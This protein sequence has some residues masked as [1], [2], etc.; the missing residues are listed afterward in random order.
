[1][2]VKW[3]KAVDKYNWYKLK[4]LKVDFIFHVIGFIDLMGTIGL[5]IIDYFLAPS[6]LFDDN[7]Y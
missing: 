2:L 4:D 7:Y 5:K 3:D 6:P 1:M